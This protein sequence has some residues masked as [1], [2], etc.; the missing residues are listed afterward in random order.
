MSNY[1]GNY[2]KKRKGSALQTVVCILLSIILLGVIAGGIFVGVKSEGFRNWDYFKGEQTEQVVPE[3]GS[4]VTDGEGNELESGTSYE[5]PASMVYAVPTAQSTTASSGVTVTATVLPE[6]AI[7]KNVT[8][9]LAFADAS[10]S[11]AQGKTVTDY[12]TVTADTENSREATVV[13][14][15]AFGEQIVL[16]AASVADPTKTATCTIDYAQSL[17]SYTLSF[18]S[19]VCNFDGNTDVTMEL[20]ANAA[21]I[22]GGLPEEEIVKNEVYTIADEYVVTY[23]LVGHKFMSYNGNYQGVQGWF[24]FGGNSGAPNYDDEYA[25]FSDYQLSEKGLYFGLKWMND[26]MQLRSVG[27]GMG[28]LSVNSATTVQPEEF[29]RRFD[30]AG[31]QYKPGDSSIT[32]TY[33]TDMDLLDLEV[34]VEG[35]YVSRVFETTFVLADYSYADTIHSVQIDPPSIVF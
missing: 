20:D 26:N 13:C 9:S 8:W 30:N 6:T 23:S 17:V 11:W 10:A 27:G 1:Y 33:G 28:N 22:P 3:E 21:S 2:N 16:T 4:G 34:T 14:K 31:Q 19:V 29:I 25:D 24:I 15:Q 32:Y 5:M 12:V 35:T 18:G 7:N